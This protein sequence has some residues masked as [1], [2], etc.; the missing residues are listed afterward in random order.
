[1][2]HKYQENTH[3][4]NQFTCTNKW[5]IHK[6]DILLK[7]ILITPNKLNIYYSWICIQVM[8][9]FVIITHGMHVVFSPYK[10]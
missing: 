7:K 9:F 8:W 2:V 4:Y 10:Y 6:Y 5:I 1:M 3:N